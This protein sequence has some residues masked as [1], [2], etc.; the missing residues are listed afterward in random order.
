MEQV[1]VRRSVRTPSLAASPYHY[2]PYYIS[3]MQLDWLA[4][5]RLKTCHI[6]DSAVVLRQYG[7]MSAAFGAGA[8][9]NY[10]MKSQS[11]PLVL[12]RLIAHGLQQEVLPG[13]ARFGLDVASA[14]E[15]Q[16]VLQAAVLADVDPSMVAGRLTLSNPN[17]HKN[18]I[19]F[20]LQAGVRSFV[21]HDFRLLYELE[22]LAGQGIKQQLEIL[23]R[24]PGPATAQKTG[25]MKFGASPVICQQL[26]LTAAQLGMQPVGLAVHIGWQIE[27]EASMRL[28]M[29][30][31]LQTMR[32]IADE[33]RPHGIVLQ[34]LDLGGGWPS[35]FRG[36]PVPP[37]AG[38]AQ[39]VGEL[40]MH[41]FGAAH[42]LRIVLEPGNFLSAAAGITSCEIISVGLSGQSN[43]LRCVASAG[44]FNGGL[45]DGH[46]PVSWYAHNQL[47]P[48]FVEPNDPLATSTRIITYGPSCESNDII[49]PE[50]RLADQPVVQS[51]IRAEL[52]YSTTGKVTTSDKSGRLILHG[53][54]AYTS[55]F[56]VGKH[57]APGFNS[58]T[59]PAVIVL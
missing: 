27:S 30:Y 3:Q 14:G 6:I 48:A 28:G 53:T 22:Q 45:L 16:K 32:E 13:R 31:A 43:I 52:D 35:Q 26:L 44:K 49:L 56:S 54:G 24:I 55:E 47:D 36:R 57:A 7:E 58:I 41:Y 4:G 15:I 9:I 40:L 37:I 33:L 21:V 11:A 38:N 18:D 25:G 23:A 1:V 8:Q 29:H 59:N 17:A 34:V 5:S 2:E 51:M 10:A 19:T 50:L 39:I 20:A 42:G 46:Y 12:Q